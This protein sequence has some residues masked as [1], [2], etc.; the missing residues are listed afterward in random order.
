MASP[1][2]CSLRAPLNSICVVHLKPAPQAEASGQINKLPLQ[3]DRGVFQSVVCAESWGQ[4]PIKNCLSH[5][6]SPMGPSNT[7]FTWSP[8][9]DNPGYP[10]GCCHRNWGTS[11]K[12]KIRTPNICKSF[13]LKDADI[14]EYGREIAQCQC[15]MHSLSKAEGMHRDGSCQLL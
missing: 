11:H 13:S 15:P 10:L 7:S 8:E 2:L 5:C 1:S 12:K 14:V 3:K 4:K 9:P 6:C